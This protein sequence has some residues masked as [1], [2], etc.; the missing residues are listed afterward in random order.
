MSVTTDVKRKEGGLAET[1]RPGARERM[2]TIAVGESGHATFED[3]GDQPLKN[4]PVPV[5]RVGTK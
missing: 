1:I 5:R 2:G 4:I 3:L